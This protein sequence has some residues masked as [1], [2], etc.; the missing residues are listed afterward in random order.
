MCQG[1]VIYQ[2]NVNILVVNIPKSTRAC[3]DMP[4]FQTKLLTKQLLVVMIL[5]LFDPDI[6]S[7]NHHMV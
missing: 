1:D 7:H 5:D 3:I 6:L 2:Q 4:G